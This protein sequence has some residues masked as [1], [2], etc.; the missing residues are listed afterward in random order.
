[1]LSLT[2]TTAG[3]AFVHTILGPDHYLPFIALAK[4]GKWSLAKTM[5]IT[6][7]CGIAHVASSIAIGTV[8]IAAGFAIGTLETIESQRGN[9]AGWM[10]LGFGITYTVWGLRHAYRKTQH[11]HWHAH[12][13]GVVHCHEHHHKGEHVHLH[14]QQPKTSFVPWAMFIVFLFGPCEPLIPLLM[15]P[16][17]TQNVA[18][19]ILLSCVFAVVTLATMCIIVAAAYLGIA[20]L[21]THSLSRFTHAGA[22]LAITACGVA[23]KLGF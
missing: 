16:A 21:S 8:G 23:I 13:N 6:L 2:L 14:D 5:L 9:I 22:G 12:A 4:S 18:G 1:M 20:K 15:F 7:T 19:I 17:A 11:T 10:L 3:I